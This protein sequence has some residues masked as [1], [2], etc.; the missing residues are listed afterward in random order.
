MLALSSSWLCTAFFWP[1]S[2]KFQAHLSKISVTWA[3]SWAFHYRTFLDVWLAPHLIG[4]VLILIKLSKPFVIFGVACVRFPWRYCASCTHLYLFCFDHPC[5][6]WLPHRAVRSF[7]F[8]T[9]KRFKSTSL[10]PGGYW[11]VLSINS[12]FNYYADLAK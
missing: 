8:E 1:F 7:Y 11:L 9:G 4:C 2:G 6:W 12:F 3:A 5:E 10:L